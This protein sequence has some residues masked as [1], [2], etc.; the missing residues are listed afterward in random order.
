VVVLSVGGF[1]RLGGDTVGFRQLLTAGP[2]TD[3]L[4]LE[5]DRAPARRVVLPDL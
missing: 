5:R 3:D 4:Q 1:R 2:P